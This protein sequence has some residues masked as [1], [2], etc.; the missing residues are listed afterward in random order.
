M[1]KSILVDDYIHLK[2]VEEQTRLFEN[3]IRR[4]M[5]D[6]TSDAII[7]GLEL[8][9]FKY[10]NLQNIDTS[11]DYIK[12]TYIKCDCSK[13]QL[14]LLIDEYKNKYVGSS[15]EEF[16]NFLIK[17]TNLNVKL[18]KIDDVVFDEY[19]SS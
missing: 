11:D 2:I 15:C 6:V 9:S 12:S 5:S 4:N 19:N 16:I 3:G 14:K 18:I 10:Y 7:T 17:N 1:V 13:E 8:N